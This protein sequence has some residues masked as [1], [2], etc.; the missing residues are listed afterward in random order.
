M[1]MKKLAATFVAGSLALS[2]S[3]TALA[4]SYTVSSNS[5]MQA[6][7]QTD[8]DSI[9]FTLSGN[10]ADDYIGLYDLQGKTI[11]INGE[12]YTLSFVYFIA[13]YEDEARADVTVNLK[14]IDNSA[15]D[16]V[17]DY[18]VEGQG[19]MDLTITTE[20]G[21]S[22]AAQGVYGGDYHPN[23]AELGEDASSSSDLKMTINGDV[24]AEYDGVYAE[25][26]ADITVN[27][28]VT[29]GTYAYGV[30]AQDEATVTINGDV[31][32]GYAGV[33]ATADTAEDE[34]DTP[35]VTITVNGDV[36]GRD[37]DADDEYNT[38]RAGDGVVAYG[39]VSVTV[40]GD[41]TG[42]DNDADHMTSSDNRFYAG[43]GVEAGYGAE[44]TVTG[45]V[46]GGDGGYTSEWYDYEA[47]AGVIIDGSAT[48]TVGGDV[49]G[50]SSLQGDGGDGIEIYGNSPDEEIT[51]TV[52]GDVTG[53]E[54]GT[55][56]MTNW[57]TGDLY[58]TYAGAGIDASD[59]QTTDMNI[60]VGGDV[61]GGDAPDDG[62][63]YAGDG[64][65]VAVFDR[66]TSQQEA[67]GDDEAADNSTIRV[68][69][70]ISAGSGG[71][72][73]GS[74]AGIF[75]WVGGSS[76]AYFAY[77]ASGMSYFDDILSDP[78]EDTVEEILEAYSTD[79]ISET[80]W[81]VI[82]LENGY[83]SMGYLDPYTSDL[84]TLSI[85]QQTLEELG[86]EAPAT[87]DV[88]GDDAEAL[89]TEAREEAEAVLCNY[90]E[91]MI[92]TEHPEYTDDE[93]AEA[94][95]SLHEEMTDAMAESFYTQM[96]DMLK[97]TSHEI[98]KDY[99]DDMIIPQITCWSIDDSN[100]TAVATDSASKALAQALQDNDVYYTI[101][102]EENEGAVITVDNPVAQEGDTVTVTVTP[103]IGYEV[104]SVT[105]TRGEMT[106]NGDGTYSFVV[107]ANGGYD[108]SVE[109][110]A[111]Q[112]EMIEET[113][114]WTIG[115]EGTSHFKATG[116]YVIFTGVKI[117]GAEISADNY[118]AYEGSTA[119]D[120]HS[121][122]VNSLAVGQ[123]TISICYSNGTEVT[124]TF[125]VK[126]A[127]T[128][129]ETEETGET[130]NGGSANGGSAN[131]GSASG[132]NSSSPATDDSTP[133]AM[134]LLMM[135]ASALGMLLLG[136]K[137]R[138]A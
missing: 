14:G 122:Y 61:T 36:S 27:G 58:M 85:Y 56:T 15:A 53:G 65:I 38:Y 86:L 101:R 80:M 81:G 108:I 4:D 134:W 59:T 41:V 76:Q 71:I 135:A 73:D 40:D 128:K 51:V 129:E 91:E 123:H 118:D 70:T 125:T 127:E 103:E 33:Y 42:G 55:S 82:R 113:P 23:Y 114:L 22:S 2:M 6:I 99:E 28:D 124:A 130:E 116:P 131:G 68:G 109:T 54:S 74:Q 11:V 20:D 121:D 25:D 34:T 107:E 37:V 92:R 98:I 87:P 138:R 119:V 67:E 111:I 1:K 30:E 90:L 26:G 88:T 9:I 46:T 45:D 94:V 10:Y 120:L 66:E 126:A 16:K 32:G 24:D 95:E 89:L 63:N 110:E 105:N 39:N 17:Q 104:K 136:K 137:R 78:T 52:G 115:Q 50:G 117:D 29:G 44:V 7:V 93:V 18:A 83:E 5:E 62:Y 132:T 47:G 57:D 77:N 69:G 112:Y 75:Y 21:I 3:V 96:I 97:E 72:G 100:G 31:S 102:T 79:S 19:N 8:D 64:I 13:G 35:D 60:T 84:L 49:T 106:D 43:S 48:V 12:E 133:I